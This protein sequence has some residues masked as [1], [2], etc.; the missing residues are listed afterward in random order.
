MEL[1]PIPDFT[2]YFA[3]SDGNI[4]T[5]LKQGCRNRFDKSKWTEPRILKPRY[6]KGYARV[7][8][9]RDSTNKREDLYI[10]RLIGEIFIPNPNNLPQINHKDCNRGNNVPS[11][12]EWVTLKENLRYANT[13][14]FMS[15]DKL[16]RFCH[17]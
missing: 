3:G 2:G 14:G 1:R 12:L 9:R 10:H 16:G 6:V 15:R 17:K 4:Y 11:N 8:L 13:N 5:V 7:Y